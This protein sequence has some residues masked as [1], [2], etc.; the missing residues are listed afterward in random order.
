VVW[1]AFALLTVVAGVC[2]LVAGRYPRGL[3]DFNVGVCT[4]PGD[5]AIVAQSIANNRSQLPT[6][7]AGD[8]RPGS[9]SP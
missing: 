1:T 3:F 7:P 4:G 5:A 9:R 2:F 6:A 8:V